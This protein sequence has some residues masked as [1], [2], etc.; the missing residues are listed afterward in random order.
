[1]HLRYAAP[2][3]RRH[4]SRAPY[5]LALALL[6]PGCANCEDDYPATEEQAAPEPAPAPSETND[7]AATARR[8]QAVPPPSGPTLPTVALAA[9]LPDVLGDF[10]AQA[11]AEQVTLDLGPAGRLPKVERV[12]LAGN[13]VLTIELMDARHAPLARAIITKQ[14][15]QDRSTETGTYRGEML[16]GHPGIV[17]W[18]STDQ[19][20]S[21]AVAIDD[22]LVLKATVAPARLDDAAAVLLGKLDIPALAALAARPDRAPA[23]P[24]PAASLSTSS[25]AAPPKK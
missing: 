14:Q 25:T 17:Q 5:R 8:R 9:Q 10:V 1:M 6:L 13:A 21:A 24:P 11:P 2:V 4:V 18:S 16:H 7:E 12:Y 22:R 23:Q 19:E 3:T 20:A 15:G